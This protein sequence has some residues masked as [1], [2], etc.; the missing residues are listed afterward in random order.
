MGRAKP[1]EPMFRIRYRSLEAA[2]GAPTEE[3]SVVL[4]QNDALLALNRASASKNGGYGIIGIEVV[5][6]GKKHA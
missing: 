4:A 2:S 3:R 5:Q 1:A 6:G